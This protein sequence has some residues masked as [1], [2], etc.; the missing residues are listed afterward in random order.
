MVGLVPQGDEEETVEEAPPVTVVVMVRTSRKVVSH[1]V[2][3]NKSKVQSYNFQN[4]RH[5]AAECGNPRWE[6]DHENNFIK[7][8]VDNEPNLLLSTP[9]E[10]IVEVFLN[11]ENVTLQLNSNGDY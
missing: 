8:Q 1:P 2:V 6:R 9:S 5:Y 11:E 3:K 10:K 7:E 4:Y